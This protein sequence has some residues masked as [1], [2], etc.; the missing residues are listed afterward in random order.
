VWAAAQFRDGRS[1]GTIST[2]SGYLNK[3]IRPTDKSSQFTWDIHRRAIALKYA[4]QTFSRAAEP[5]SSAQVETFV[6]QAIA[7]LQEDIEDS[8]ATPAAV[9]AMACLGLRCAD[10]R[11]IHRADFQRRSKKKVWIR[12]RVAKN[13]RK[14]SAGTILRISPAFDMPE[15]FFGWLDSFKSTDRPFAATSSGKINMWLKRRNAQSASKTTRSY[16]LR[17]YFVKIKAAALR[18]DWGKVMEETGNTGVA[19]RGCTR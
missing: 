11:R 7:A 12:I 9:I 19:T 4:E 14:K 1:W 8:Q 13:R 17:K 10:L 6:A 16:S 5:A 2:Y 3:I 15:G 18:Y